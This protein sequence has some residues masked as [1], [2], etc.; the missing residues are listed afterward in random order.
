MDSHEIKI[1][2]DRLIPVPKE[3]QIQGR[4]GISDC[5]KMQSRDPCRRNRRDL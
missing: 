4:Q 3:D 5:R 1:L 2:T